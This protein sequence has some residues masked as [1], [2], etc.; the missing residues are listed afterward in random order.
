LTR[1][2]RESPTAPL[3][4]LATVQDLRLACRLVVDAFVGR[5][6]PPR[7]GTDLRHLD[8]RR[9]RRR[10][11]RVG[12]EDLGPEARIV[13]AVGGGPSLLVRD[14]GA[15]A[16]RLESA[17]VL[18]GA[19][20]WLLLRRHREVGVVATSGGGTVE[21]PPSRAPVQLGRILRALEAAEP[22][23]PDFE[24]VSAALVRR[25]REL[26]THGI[27]V[28]DADAPGAE[29]KG[30]MVLRLLPPGA[31]LGGD[32][33]QLALHLDEHPVHALRRILGP[34]PRA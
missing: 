7:P 5:P 18:A 6:R 3:R 4:L 24:G 13:I 15:W 19:L 25:A 30:V 32:G 11:L 10:A 12:S 8:W 28:T 31:P 27:F 21:A 34:P 20:A 14:A 29:Q 23:R 26:G 1:D 33:P 22:S 16:S 9:W 2:V 17:R